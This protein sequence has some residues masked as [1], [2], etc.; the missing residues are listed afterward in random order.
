MISQWPLDLQLVSV[1]PKLNALVHPLRTSTTCAL[2]EPFMSFL[3]RDSIILNQDVL[4]SFASKLQTKTRI[5]EIRDVLLNFCFMYSTCSTVVYRVILVDFPIAL[6]L[7]RSKQARFEY[8]T[9]LV[10][11]LNM[12]TIGAMA[13]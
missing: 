8:I 13:I 6:F 3:A 1:E 10:I 12:V 2:V 9:G 4:A 7:C 5:E 11:L